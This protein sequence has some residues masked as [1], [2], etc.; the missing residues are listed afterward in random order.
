MK[1]SGIPF[2]HGMTIVAVVFEAMS[3]PWPFFGEAP[4]KREK[5]DVEANASHPSFTDVTAK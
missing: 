1:P 5:S 3:A 4:Y 2:R